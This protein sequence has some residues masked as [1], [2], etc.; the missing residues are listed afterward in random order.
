M[1]P[2]ITKGNAFAFKAEI[3]RDNKPLDVEK[4]D[5]KVFLISPMG[6]RYKVNIYENKSNYIIC[7]FK[8]NIPSLIYGFE[9]LLNND[10]EKFRV[11]I[12]EA[13]QIVEYSEDSDPFKTNEYNTT[14][15]TKIILSIK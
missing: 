10:I 4:Y 15:N 14:H 8:E 13:L 3:F 6:K 11:P 5:T 12:K 1:I 9:I 7:D 2:K